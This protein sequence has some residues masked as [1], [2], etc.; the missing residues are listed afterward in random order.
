MTEEKKGK[1]GRKEG[2]Q[3]SVSNPRSRSDPLF[4]LGLI[5]KKGG[6]CSVAIAIQAAKS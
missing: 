4:P 5:K 3:V 2:G 6:Q 1:K